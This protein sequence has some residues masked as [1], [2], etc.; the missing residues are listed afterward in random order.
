MIVLFVLG[1]IA[2]IR[3]LDAD[4]AREREERWRAI[5]ES[6]EQLRSYRQALMDELISTLPFKAFVKIDGAD[7]IMGMDEDEK[8]LRLISCKKE[9][10]SLTVSNDKTLSV[11]KIRSVSIDRPLKN[12]NIAT[13]VEKMP[14]AVG[15]N[16]SPVG[17][18]LIGGA[19][20]GP[21][22]ALVGGMS[23]L[24]GKSEIEMVETRRYH[25]TIQY[26]SYPKL[27]IVIDDLE[28]PR[29]MFEFDS[30]KE[31]NEWSARIFAAINRKT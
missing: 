7:G 20:A 30:I 6:G 31:T 19:I 13:H 18:A 9:Q 15:S 2:Q 14:V 24:G 23:G 12:L 28:S 10:S 29:H 8:L 1:L 11:E 26:E 5:K 17:R 4:M 22:G 21:V 3:R 25:E 27:V 16:R